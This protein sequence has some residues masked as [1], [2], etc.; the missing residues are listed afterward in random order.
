MM[1][2]CEIIENNFLKV[3]SK[4][5]IRELYKGHSGCEKHKP[6][7]TN[8]YNGLFASG[9]ETELSQGL[10]DLFYEYLGGNAES[11]CRHQKLFP[12]LTVDYLEDAFRKAS[13]M[14]LPKDSLSALPEAFLTFPHPHRG[15]R[16]SPAQRNHHQKNRSPIYHESISRHDLKKQLIKHS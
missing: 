12:N 8:L 10:L 1:L 5:Q 16:I 7:L 9:Y 3:L 6:V 11:F 4:D 2:T 14:I 15:M 13:D